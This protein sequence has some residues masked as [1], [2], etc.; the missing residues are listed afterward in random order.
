[1]FVRKSLIFL[2]VMSLCEQIIPCIFA[3]SSNAWSERHHQPA[4]AGPHEYLFNDVFQ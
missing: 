4:I 1:M 3:S 2:Y